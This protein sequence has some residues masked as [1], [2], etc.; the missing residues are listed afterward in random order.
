MVKSEIIKQLKSYGIEPVESTPRIILLGLLG[1][2]MDEHEA[3]YLTSDVIVFDDIYYKC[4]MQHENKKRNT[5][6]S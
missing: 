2:V 1:T 4:G 3:G 6:D 5:K